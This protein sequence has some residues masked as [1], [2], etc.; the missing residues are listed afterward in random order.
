MEDKLDK[1]D[2]ITARIAAA[3]ELIRLKREVDVRLDL[4]L[5]LTGIGMWD[6]E[7]EADR[8]TWDDRM[9]ALFDEPVE[10]RKTY[11][12]FFGKL[13]P[14]DRARVQ[15]AIDQALAGAPYEIDYTIVVGDGSHRKIHA[16]GLR[17]PD[18]DKPE[19]LIGVC[20]ELRA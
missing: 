20:M 11:E 16:R 13:I 5:T 7:V 10:T 6:W 4:A 3:A 1:L 15:T 19:K 18:T 12:T 14:E 17:H 8:L 9:C 2:S